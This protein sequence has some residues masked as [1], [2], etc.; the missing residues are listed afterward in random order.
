M[1]VFSDYINFLRWCQHPTGKAPVGISKIDWQELLSF[2]KKQ[3]V[4]GIYW[5]GIQRLGDVANRPS[6][7]DVMDW[8]G[9]TS[10]S[11]DEIRRRTTL[12]H[13]SRSSCR[14]KT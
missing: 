2:A 3:T 7:D 1:S 9:N 10:K 12:L 5:Q 14:V 6:E 11:S 13:G 8:M 4:I